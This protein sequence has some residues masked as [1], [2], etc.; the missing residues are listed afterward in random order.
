MTLANFFTYVPLR[1]AF[2][3]VSLGFT[4]PATCWGME[5][6]RAAS[7]RLHMS[8]ALDSNVMTVMRAGRGGGVVCRRTGANSPRG[9]G[10][11]QAGTAGHMVVVAGAPGKLHWGWGSA[12]SELPDSSWQVMWQQHTSI[13]SVL[14]LNGWKSSDDRGM[15]TFI[16]HH[17]KDRDETILKGEAVWKLKYITCLLISFL[18]T[19]T[20]RAAT[21]NCCGYPDTGASAN[22]HCPDWTYLLCHLQVE[23]SYKKKRL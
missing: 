9:L 20:S 19:R 8:W 21:S 13:L 2:S 3:V 15:E 17:G 16:C 14:P 18:I 12:S 22:P 5:R 10:K 4:C 7:W 23:K 6:A 1:R 11:G